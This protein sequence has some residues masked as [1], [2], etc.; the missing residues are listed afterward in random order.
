MD[1]T[2]RSAEADKTSDAFTPDALESDLAHAN[3]LYH[4]GLLAIEHATDRS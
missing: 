2:R 1:R 3:T 4:A